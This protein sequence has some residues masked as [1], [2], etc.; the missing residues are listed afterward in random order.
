[1]AATLTRV[2]ATLAFHS[3]R[4]GVLD[5]A[6]RMFVD[7]SMAYDD[8]AVRFLDLLP[9]TFVLMPGEFTVA[10]T[11][12]SIDRASA[13][14]ARLG[15]IWRELNDVY[16]NGVR[17]TNFA[18]SPTLASAAH[19]FCL[20]LHDAPDYDSV[21]HLSDIDGEMTIVSDESTSFITSVSGVL[22]GS[23]DTGFS[24]ATAPAVPTK[25]SERLGAKARADA[26]AKG[27]RVALGCASRNL[28]GDVS[29]NINGRHVFSA[30]ANLR[31]ANVHL[32]TLSGLAAKAHHHVLMVYKSTDQRALEE[33]ALCLTE[34]EHSCGSCDLLASVLKRMRLSPGELS[35]AFTI[36]DEGAARFNSR[37]GALWTRMVIEQHHHYDADEDVGFQHIP[38]P[39]S[40]MRLFHHIFGTRPTRDVHGQLVI[41]T[42]TPGSPHAFEGTYTRLSNMPELMTRGEAIYPPDGFDYRPWHTPGALCAMRLLHAEAAAALIPGCVRTWHAARVIQRWARMCMYDTRFKKGRRHAWGLWRQM[43]EGV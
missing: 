31:R 8:A 4:Q 17:P 42:D 21:D 7:R 29:G 25:P 27:V 33:A 14:A 6:F 10:F 32:E 9:K 40:I 37:L 1:M 19:L 38:S 16:D 20:I 2:H 43:E 11:I 30:Q 15:D 39:V 12:E 18:G 34:E 3:Q 24:T 28:R 41:V 5:A 13:S 35:L 22:G 23:A 36:D 26:A